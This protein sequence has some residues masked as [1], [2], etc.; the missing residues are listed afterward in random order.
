M[1]KMLKIIAVVSLAQFSLFADSG[2]IEKIVDGDTVK[3]TNGVNC[4][5]AYIDTPESSMNSRLLEKVHKCKNK[6]INVQ[7]YRMVE[8]GLL[9]KN[10]LMSK[11]SVNE[12]IQ[13]KIIGKDTR[14]NRSVCQLTKNNLD[15]NLQM[16]KSGYAF[17][18]YKY[19]KN[20]SIKRKYIVA[21]MEASSSYKGIYGF[22]K[23][24]MQCLASSN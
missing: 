1:K 6:G 5:L 9:S 18:Y 19:I 20:D 4:R 13:Y 10:Y 12:E 11:I 15:I 3:F 24:T 2:I 16:V 23:S 7:D 14:Y 17:P 8:A 22:D 21:N